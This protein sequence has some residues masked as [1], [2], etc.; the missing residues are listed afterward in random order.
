MRVAALVLLGLVLIAC[1][2][3]D[4]SSGGGTGGTSATGGSGG[5]GGSGAT[6]ATGGAGGTG[7]SGTGGSGGT[8][9]GAY[10]VMPQAEL[11]ALPVSGDAW[12]YLKARADEAVAI[13]L[14]AGSE[15]SPWLPNYND[16]GAAQRVP[17][18]YL[19]AALVV[20][21]AF[22]GDKAPYRAA[23]AAAL[24]HV[25][26]S[27][28]EA[29]TDGTAAGDRLLA[30]ARQLPAWVL[31]ADLIALDGSLTG[32][33][34]TPGSDSGTDW[35]ATTFDDWLSSVRTK[36]IGTHGRW[37]NITLTHENSAANWGAH[38]AASRVAASLY[39]GDDSDVDR[40]A[41][42][43]RGAMGDSNA[44]PAYPDG[45]NPQDGEGFQTTSSFD[46]SWA[47]N[48]SATVGGWR[49]I[50]SGDCGAAMDGIVV[51]DMSRSAGAYPNYDDTGIGYAF[52]TMA[53]LHLA[54]LLLD[55]QGVAA[56]SWSDDALKRAMLWL[57]G[58]GQ[59]PGSGS[60]RQHVP[61]ITNHF[62]GTNLPTGEARMGRGFGF[63]DW[64]YP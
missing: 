32:T 47:C 34:T 18:R 6:T 55:R 16:S 10:L 53:G 9:S 25:M 26:G 15:A 22:D 56:F 58:E 61:W 50:N 43:L 19:A 5:S 7:A 49:P 41:T 60:V 17:A 14:D 13:T 4:T 40:A 23:V 38:C 11:E 31:S 37:T 8:T 45:Q 57:D 52:E 28:E 48:Y 24:R 54:A 1:D 46:S 36:T 51:E 59:V 44:Y 29:S 42:V 3:D 27:E 62:Y 63:T 39:L 35:T 64:L 33:R 21:S 20:A 2:G 30:T 12:D